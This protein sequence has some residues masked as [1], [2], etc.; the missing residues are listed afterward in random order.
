MRHFRTTGT[1]W[2]KR[3]V[4]APAE[5]ATVITEPEELPRGQAIELLRI[6]VRTAGPASVYAK[7]LAKLMAVGSDE[8]TTYDA[9]KLREA[10]YIVWNTQARLDVITPPGLHA[11][12]RI[13]RAFATVYGIHQFARA[14]GKGSGLSSA[15]SCGW[16]SPYCRD[17]RGGQS[18]LRTHET[19]HLRMVD[20]GKWPPRPIEEFLN[21]V[22][23]PRLPLQAQVA[24]KRGEP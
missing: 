6:R 3:I 24:E 10:G 17:S 20:E 18:A 14:G 1:A 22:M 9:T 8:P 23:P 11:A 5:P 4:D 12:G 2:R 15:C 16:R 13:M 21:E 19:F 7:V